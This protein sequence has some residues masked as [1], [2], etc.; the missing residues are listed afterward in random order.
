MGANL[1]VG[2]IVEND[3]IKC[4]F[5]HWSFSGKDGSLVDI[6]YSEDL[7]TSKLFTF[8]VANC[9]SYKTKHISL[10]KLYFMAN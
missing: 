4:P 6:P 10:I 7:K 3:C 8:L 5:H 9:R 1:G 2:G